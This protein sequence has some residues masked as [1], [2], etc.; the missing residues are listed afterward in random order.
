MAQRRLLFLDASKLT[1]YTWQGGQL[2]TGREFI[3]DA[4]GVEAFEKYL[5]KNV[6][7]IFSILADVA[8]EGFQIEDVPFVRGRDRAAISAA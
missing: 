3:A 8:E 6:K 2:R 4:A 7:S 1:A 5:E